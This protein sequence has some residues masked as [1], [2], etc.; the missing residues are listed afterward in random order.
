MCCNN[1]QLL[2]IEPAADSKRHELLQD[3]GRCHVVNMR[4]EETPSVKKP[5]LPHHRDWTSRLLLR[6]VVKVKVGQKLTTMAFTSQGYKKK[7]CYYYDGEWLC[8]CSWGFGRTDT[9][10]EVTVSVICC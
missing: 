1:L 3:E 8:V 5:L 9:L 4:T 10:T 6:C 7:V 2:G